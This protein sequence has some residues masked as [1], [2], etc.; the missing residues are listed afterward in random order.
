ME[1][2]FYLAYFAIGALFALAT[3][4]TCHSL[5]ERVAAWPFYALAY[6]LLFAQR[7]RQVVS[8]WIWDRLHRPR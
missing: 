8:D 2:V 6:L 1:W 5:A 4:H 7:L 3:R